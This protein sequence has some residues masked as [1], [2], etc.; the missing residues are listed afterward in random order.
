[1]HRSPS[2]ARRAVTPARTSPSTGQPGSNGLTLDPQGRLTINR[3]RQPA[4]D[5]HREGRRRHRARGSLRRQTAEQSE[6]PGLSLRRHAVLH[7]SALRPAE[8]LRRS[9][10]G[11]ARSAVSYAGAKRQAQAADE[12][13]HG[14]EWHRVLARTRSTSTSATGTTKAKIVKRYDARPGRHRFKR[15]A[16]LRHDHRARRRRHRRHE[17]GSIPATSTCPAPVASGF[18]RRKAST[19]APSLRRSIRTISTGAD[20]MAGRCTSAPN[21]LSTGLP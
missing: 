13:V 21:R 2:T 16:L 19:S 10:E 17:G 1:M 9:S 14:S 18:C 7:R 15:E 5:S 8:V 3:A 4:C 20:P 11:T 12:G 6:R